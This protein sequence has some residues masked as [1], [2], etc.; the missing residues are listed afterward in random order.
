MKAKISEALSGTTN[1]QSTYYSDAVRRAARTGNAS[2]KRAEL[3]RKKAEGLVLR[4]LW[5]YPADWHS[6]R[7][8]ADKLA[9]RRAKRSGSF[10]ALQIQR[11]RGERRPR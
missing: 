4:S 11:R 5:I 6:I 10:E 9:M 3:I 2:R 7:Q 8:F 1:P